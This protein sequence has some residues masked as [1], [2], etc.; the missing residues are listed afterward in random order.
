MKDMTLF[1]LTVIDAPPVAVPDGVD[2]T[3]TV[4]YVTDQHGTWRRYVSDD[5]TWAVFSVADTLQRMARGMAG[6]V[7]AEDAAAVDAWLVAQGVTVEGV[8]V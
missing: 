3:A 6:L 7:R 4:F 1:D 2:R 8:G 5:P